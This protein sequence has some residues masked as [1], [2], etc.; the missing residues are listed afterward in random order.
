MREKRLDDIGAK[1]YL[2]RALI[3]HLNGNDKKAKVYKNLIY[4]HLFKND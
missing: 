1:A 4:K 2:Q 3:Y